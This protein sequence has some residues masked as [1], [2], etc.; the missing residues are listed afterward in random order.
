M[1]IRERK[2][3]NGKFTAVSRFLKTPN[4]SK[5]DKDTQRFNEPTQDAVD[6]NKILADYIKP[7]REAIEKYNP[8]T[9]VEL[10]NIV[11]GKECKERKAIPT[12][13]EYLMQYYARRKEEA[14][15]SHQ[16]F[17]A[18]INKLIFAKDRNDEYRYN[19][20]DIPL[21]KVDD[22]VY[23]RFCDYVAK[24]LK[25]ENFDNTTTQF[26]TVFNDARKKNIVSRQLTY[27][28]KNSLIIDPYKELKKQDDKPILNEE[29]YKQLLTMDLT[30]FLKG[31]ESIQ[32]LELYRDFCILLFEL[33]SRP[34]DIA[35][36][37]RI[38]INGDE[39]LYYITKKKKERIETRL[40]RATITPIAAKVID[41]YKDS[42]HAG[43]LLPLVMYEDITESYDLTAKGVY[44]KFYNKWNSKCLCKINDFLHR[45]TTALG[46]SGEKNLTTYRFRHSTITQQ[47]NKQ[48]NPLFVAQNAGTSLKYIQETYYHK[49]QIDPNFERWYQSRAMAI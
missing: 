28:A 45:I 31:E 25:G 43:Y 38:G 39:I 23:K 33:S 30:P 1:Q 22:E 40:C 3:T 26:K 14:S 21:N 49:K 35:T 7:Y 19:F 42:H 34:M 17:H 4:Y 41:K 6:N 46:F 36:M 44:D 48:I 37:Q 16:Q 10:I 12:Y 27:K 18:L 47:I 11:T 8:A 29:Q 5:W 2:E 32:E 15:T 13:G 9:A 24:P 20:F